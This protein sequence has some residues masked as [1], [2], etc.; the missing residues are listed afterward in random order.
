MSDDIATPLPSSAV[1]EN[2]Q[3]PQS[4]EDLD[5]V[6]EIILGPDT[7]RQRLRRSEV[8]R[9]REIL[10]GAQIEEYDRR[11]ADLRRDIDRVGVDLRE[12]Q[13]RLGEIE[14]GMLRRFDLL[15]LELRKLSEDQRRESERQ[16]SRDSLLQQMT[17]Q[18][19]QHEETIVGLGEGVIDLRKTSTSHDGELRAAKSSLVDLRDQQEQ[20]T[21]ALRREI[22]HA[23]DLLRAELR[24]IADRLENQKTD[25]K[26]LAGMLMEIATRLETGHSV[27]GLL[28]GLNSPKE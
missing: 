16:R 24:R 22:R 11:F 13:E 18:A 21:Q 14:K 12:T 27:T 17:A 3:P 19:R 5:R 4:Q 25:R 7:V 10:F 28:E 23:E 2:G 6:R 15:D 26:A 20:R 9:L 1:P 8:D